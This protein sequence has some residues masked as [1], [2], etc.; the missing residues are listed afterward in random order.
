ME[1]KRCPSC[2][3]GVALELFRKPVREGVTFRLVP[4]A[5]DVVQANGWSCE[6]CGRKA[7]GR[8]RW[9]DGAEGATLCWEC[10]RGYRVSHEA[11]EG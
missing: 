2:R 7:V 1:K 8:L 3:T 11:H 5:G 10:W 9:D 6:G 4:P